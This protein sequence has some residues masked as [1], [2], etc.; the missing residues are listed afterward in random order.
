MTGT[1]GSRAA[2]A[3]TRRWPPRWADCD[4]SRTCTAA[5]CAPLTWAT[6][7]CRTYRALADFGPPKIDFLLPHGTWE[8]PPPGRIPGDRPAPRTRTGSSRSSITGIRS[9]RPGSACSRRSCTC[10]S[11]GPAIPRSSGSRRPGWWSSRPTAPSSRKTRSRSPTTGP[12][13]PACTWRAI[14]WTRR[15]CCRRSSAARS[16]PGRWPRS[17]G[18]ARSA[19]VCGGGLYSHRYRE[20]TGFLNPSVY[21]PDLLALISHIRDRVRADLRPAAPGMPPDAQRP[22]TTLGTAHHSLTAEQFAALARGGG[23]TRR[24]AARGRPAQ[25]A[26]D[27]A[28]QGRGAGPARRSPG[29]RARRGRAR[30]ACPGAAAGPGDAAGE[31]IGYPSVGA[32]ALHTIRRCLRQ[33]RVARP[34]GLATVAA[35]AAIRAGLDAEIEVPV[36][37]GRRPAAIPRRRRRRRRHCRRRHQGGR[38]PVG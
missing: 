14:R 10:C 2:G 9:R 32:W 5:C 26:P 23:D 19:R 34:S 33:C 16:G 11:A 36:L 37:D 35:A 4:G 7:P 17:A 20:G 30:T 1:A 28:G 25:Q 22:D 3:A 24:R 8:D 29:R 27:P 38:G 18:S 13:R 6:T 31:V 21:C 15:C 12:R